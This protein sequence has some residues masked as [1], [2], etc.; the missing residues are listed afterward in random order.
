[1]EIIQLTDQHLGREGEDTYGIDVRANFLKAL[2]IIEEQQPD[3][4]VLTGDMCYRDPEREIYIWAKQQLDKLSVPFEIIS[5]NH[6]DPVMM[7]DVFGLNEVLKQDGIYYTKEIAGEPILFLETSP[8]E[9]FPAQ[10]DWLGQQ[11]AGFKQDLIIFMHHP[12]MLCDVPFMDINHA[13]KNRDE[14]QE[15]LFSYPYNLSIFTGHYH[16]E[17]TMRIRNIEV[18]ITPSTF[19]QISRNSVE[20]EVAHQNP[21]YRVI[22]KNGGKT[23]HS[24]VY[25]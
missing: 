20:F 2:H 17:R 4:L 14:I 19:F 10:L 3:C 7:A 24:V 22:K 9:I 25:F 13:F 11:L 23:G 1:M 8:A 6:D 15:V 18:N 21:A 12:P 16:V 5:G